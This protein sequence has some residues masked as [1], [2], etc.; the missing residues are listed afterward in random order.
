MQE[1]ERFEAEGGNTIVLRLD[2]EQWQVANFAADGEQLWVET[3]V[4]GQHPFTEEEA[5]AEYKRWNV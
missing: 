1:V 4:T 5:R 3:S 2:G